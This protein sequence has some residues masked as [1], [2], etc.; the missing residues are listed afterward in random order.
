MNERSFEILVRRCAE[1]IFGPGWRL[2]AQQ[3]T[4]RSGR[5]DLLFSDS[6]GQRHLVELKKGRGSV[7]AVDQ[8]LRYASDLTGLLDGAI[9]V[10][11]VVAHEIPFPVSEA[12]K[13]RGV[14]TRA[15]SLIEC[16]M[17]MRSAG[18]GERDL[19]GT[20]REAGILHGGSGRGG[21]QQSVAIETAYASIP[22][23]LARVLRGLEELEHFQ[24]R[25]GNMQTVVHYRGV[26]LGGVNRKHRGGVAYIAE[27]VVLNMEFSTMLGHLGFRRMTKTQ[28]RGGHEHIW[29]EIS[30]VHARAFETAIH[31]AR[32]VVNRSLQIR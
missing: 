18:I 14:R 7:E 2:I 15:V 23:A 32:D 20:R 26:K 25:S 5:L 10:P 24:V 11:W 29:W 17:L 19:F 28:A 13:H 16:E 1:S 3:L 30:A 9:P 31:A 6:E 27:G 12:A 8:V 21:V 22:E 4:L